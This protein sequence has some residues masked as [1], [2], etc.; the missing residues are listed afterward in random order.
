MIDWRVVVLRI[1]RE[2]GRRAF[3]SLLLAEHLYD[4]VVLGIYMNKPS[5]QYA[6]EFF[7]ILI[8]L[9]MLGLDV[10]DNST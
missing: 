6:S 2:G 4:H 10:L 5:V 8:S 1:R 7:H 3:R 9:V